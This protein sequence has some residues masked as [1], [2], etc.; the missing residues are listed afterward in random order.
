M[1]NLHALLNALRNLL[2]STNMITIKE[3]DAF[4]QTKVLDHI[5]DIENNEFNRGLTLEMQLI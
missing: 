5:L 1:S 3:L 2:P 4:Y